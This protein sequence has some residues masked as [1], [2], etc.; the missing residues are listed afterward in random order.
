MLVA[1]LGSI[2]LSAFHAETSTGSRINFVSLRADRDQIES[3]RAVDRV[4]LLVQ[5]RWGE[6]KI[7]RD[8][9][10]LKRFIGGATKKAYGVAIRLLDRLIYA[11]LRHRISCAQ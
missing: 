2:G 11:L 4:N 6:D 5:T 10:S 3:V 8:D 9:G 1:S 7:L